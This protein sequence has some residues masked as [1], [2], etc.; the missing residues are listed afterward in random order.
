MNS[1]QRT[2]PLPFVTG[3]AVQRYLTAEEGLEAAR[4]EGCSHWYVDA[5]LMQDM[6]HNWSRDRRSRL[7]ATAADYGLRP[8]LH[9]NFRAPLASE[10]PEVRAASLDYVRSEVDL[11]ASIGAEALVIHGGAFV[12]PRPTKAHRDA[13][14]ERF[15][16]LLSVVER[17][18]A[19]KGVEVW[20]ENLSYYP[21]YRPFSYVFTREADFSEVLAEIPHLKFVLDVGHAN[22]NQSMALPAFMSFAPSIAALALSNNSG[23]QDAHL[24]LTE[25]TLS[26]R[27]LT[28]VIR[29]L[30]WSGLIAFETRNEGVSA[31]VE[32]LRNMWESGANT[33]LVAGI[34]A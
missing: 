31:G 12:E 15:V 23:G 2:W 14:L 27:E 28:D 4:E 25:G 29:A 6:P 22:V 21:K 10:I 7:V 33:E 26:V 8:V 20:L 30:N 11:A 32:Y 18:A 3:V 19:D 9:G 16:S 24:A 1:T 13:A 34:G 5:S 17:E